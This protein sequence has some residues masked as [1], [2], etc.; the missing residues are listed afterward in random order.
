MLSNIIIFLLFITLFILALPYLMPHLPDGI[1][2]LFNNTIKTLNNSL[3]ILDIG[4]STAA[5]V[6]TNVA[7]GAGFL[8]SG[9]NPMKY[10]FN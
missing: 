7:G 9:K 3:K 5:S 8:A 10:L 6:T 2:S 4:A 1:N